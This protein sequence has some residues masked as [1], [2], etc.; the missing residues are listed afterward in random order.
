M[1]FGAFSAYIVQLYTVWDTYIRIC[2]EHT[3]TVYIGT[4][5][6]TFCKVTAVVCHVSRVCFVCAY[7]QTEPPPL[8]TSA[9]LGLATE[10][11]KL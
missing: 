10:D 5:L 4:L 9:E 6:Y 2:S 7:F 3:C 11:G 8:S 1:H